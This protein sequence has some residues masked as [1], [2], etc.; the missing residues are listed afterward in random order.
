MN[1]SDYQSQPL[2]WRTI[3]LLC[4]PALLIA[5]V[6]R[7]I[8]MTHMPYAFYIS[9][10]REF[11]GSSIAFASKLSNPFSESSRTFLAKVLYA[12]PLFFKQ[13]VLPWIAF[14]QHVFGLGAVLVAGVLCRLWL[15]HWRWWTIPL[16]ILIAIHPTLL[17]YEHMSL[18]D[19]TFVFMTLLSSMLGGIYYLNPSFRNLILLAVALFLTAGT[20][21][22]GFIFLPFG[23]MIVLGRHWPDLKSARGRIAL[24]A[25]ACLLAYLSS[26]TT[27]GGQMLVTS[28]IQMAPDQLWLHKEVSPVVTELRDEFKPRWPAYPADHNKSR[29]IITHRIGEYVDQLQATDAS[30]NDKLNNKICKRIGL[31]IALRNWWRLPGMAFNK[32]L[33]TLHEPPSPGFGQDWVHKKHLS[34]FFG[35]PGEKLPKDNHYMKTYLGREFTSR[36]EAQTELKKLYRLFSNDWLSKFQTAFVKATIGWQFPARQIQAQTVPGL[37]GFYLV[38]F[39]GLLIAAFRLRGGPSYRQLW[40]LILL[41]EAFAIFTTGSLRSRYRLIYEPWWFLGVFCML[42]AAVV[43]IRGGWG[44]LREGTPRD[45]TT[46]TV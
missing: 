42:D 10:T 23:L 13:P 6:L 33:A 34:I 36:E 8:L 32:F 24:M 39:I 44:A 4:L 1:T 12:V 27:Q 2:E 17:W 30:H 46:A 25:V 38:G 16:T 40:I 22:E 9:D 18:P 29:K 41:F 7:I 45:K 5:L 14:I 11:V 37:P 3:L 21:Q 19:S 26:R 20:R 28:T 43:L 15:T 35:K 31:E